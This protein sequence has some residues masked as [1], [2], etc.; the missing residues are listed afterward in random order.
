MCIYRA[1]Y[2]APVIDC[3][4]VGAVPKL[5]C[6]ISEDMLGLPLQQRSLDKFLADFGFG[7]LQNCWK[8]PGIGPVAGLLLRNLGYGRETILIYIY[9]YIYWYPKW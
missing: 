8:T 2:V 5:C 9:I 1:L 6:Y 4:R 3:Y 7:S